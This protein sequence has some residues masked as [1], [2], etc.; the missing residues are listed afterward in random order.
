MILFGRVGGKGGTGD[1]QTITHFL[2]SCLEGGR[3]TRNTGGSKGTQT[4]LEDGI[5]TS[6]SPGER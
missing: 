4:I 6:T 3:G 1:Q 2:F 5:T